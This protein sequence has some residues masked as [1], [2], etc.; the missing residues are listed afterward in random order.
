MPFDIGFGE[1]ILIF[2]VALI[3]FGP[4][5]LPEVGA[6]LGRAM[7]ELRRASA[8]MTTELTRSVA[9][10]LHDNPPEEKFP[11]LHCGAPNAR[12]AKFCQQC[13]KPLSEPD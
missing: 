11:C 9:P 7:R 3:V 12:S 2:L 4:G 13:G 1:I 8:E 5:R 6:T 10:Q